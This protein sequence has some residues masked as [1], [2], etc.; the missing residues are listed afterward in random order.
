VLYVWRDGEDELW[1]VDLLSRR[2]RSIDIAPEYSDWDVHPV[3]FWSL[4]RGSRSKRWW[5]YSANKSVVDH[6]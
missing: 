4:V 6:F 3:D 2:L 5:F 1:V